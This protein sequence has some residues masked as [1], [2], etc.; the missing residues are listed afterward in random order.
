MVSLENFFERVGAS[1]PFTANR[2]NGPSETDIDVP[3]I[4]E[5]AFERLVALAQEARAEGRGLGAVLWGEAGTGKSHLLSRL[6][7]WAQQDKHACPV[8]LHNLQ[9]SPENLPRSLLKSVVSILTLGRVNRFAETPLFRLVNAF[10]REALQYE[11]TLQYSW[12][13]AVRA[14]G[15]LIDQLCAADPSRAALIDRT[16]YAILFRFYRSA[17]LARTGQDDERVAGLAVRWLGGDFLDAEEAKQLDLP[18]SGMPD[19][20]VSLGDNQRIKQVLATLTR[21]AG[22]RRQ[23]FLLCFD[24]VDNLDVEQAAALAR[25]L[26]ALVDSAVNLLVVVTGIQASLLEWRGN[27]VIQDSAWDRL[28]QFE[29]PLQRITAAEGCTI[30]AARL[31]RFLEPFAELE[32]IR[33]RVREDPLF[34]LG[35]P[36][37]E[38]FLTD[39]IDVRPRDVLTW[40]R[41]GWRREQEILR[42][43]GGAHWLAGWG[44]RRRADGT[45]LEPTVEQL[46]HAI[47]QKVAQKM[48]ELKAQRQAEPYTLAPNA[49][50]LA[51][52]V[53][54]LLEQC[55]QAGC[56]GFALEVERVP[57]PKHGTRPPYDLL[58][59]QRRGAEEIDTGLLFLTTRSAQSATVA[60]RRLIRDADPPRRVFLIT[61]ER[62]ALPLGVIGK[63]YYEE[64][65]QSRGTDFR[66]IEV[67]FDQYAELDALQ[68]VVGLGRS[69]DLEIELPGG[70]PRRV[71]EKEVLES[72]Q[73]QR[74]YLAAAVLREL[75]TSEKNET[76]SAR[77]ASDSASPIQDADREESE[78]QAPLSVLET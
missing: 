23:P 27:K 70:Q 17:Y 46:H 61:D 65:R 76:E 10:L 7:R 39:K 20:P 1:N 22:S 51:G 13:Y 42:K 4:H 57:M 66:H 72:H 49:E 60:L 78:D 11:T 58:V 45:P 52:L 18:P 73:R 69:G 24:Q 19:E 28:A 62:P 38:D 59:R 12:E 43:I 25:F 36:W 15:H 9:A 64:L 5:R 8:Y 2:I 26:E 50:N 41:E 47:D 54:A 14:Y 29:I 48:A 55:Q 37:V 74:R 3:Q 16:V 71:S 67:T 30:V 34:P 53:Y 56:P 68:A 35:K 31:Q 32:P 75:L 33:R 40:A 21:M 77:P 63:E 44:T 6:W